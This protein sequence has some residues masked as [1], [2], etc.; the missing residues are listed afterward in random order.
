MHLEEAVRMNAIG[1]RQAG[2]RE[3]RIFACKLA[4]EPYFTKQ[5]AIGIWLLSK[6]ML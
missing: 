1:I 3:Q 5:D 2:N 4:L 6:S